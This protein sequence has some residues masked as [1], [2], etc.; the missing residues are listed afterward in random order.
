MG[1]RKVN[2]NALLSWMKMGR[3]PAL[4][5]VMIDHSETETSGEIGLASE[6]SRVWESVLSRCRSESVSVSYMRSP[7]L[8]HGIGCFSDTR[9]EVVGV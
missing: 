8:C 1:S 3:W 5:V 6:G 7:F 4:R 9:V 2:E